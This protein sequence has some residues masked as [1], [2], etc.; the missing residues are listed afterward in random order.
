MQMLAGVSFVVSGIIGL[1][2]GPLLTWGHGLCA[3]T[4]PAQ[5]GHG[6]WLA[7]NV[8]KL[9]TIGLLFV[10]LALAPPRDVARE[11]PKPLTHLAPNRWRS[12]TF[13][14]PFF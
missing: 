13:V 10:D 11:Q 9:L 3:T 5:C 14:V 4:S 8:C 1:L 7:I 6:H 12:I 2:A